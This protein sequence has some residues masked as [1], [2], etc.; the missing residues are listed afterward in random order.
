MTLYETLYRDIENKGFNL[1]SLDFIFQM[2]PNNIFDLAQLD[3]SSVS[4]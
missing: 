4:L 1:D 3:F 2:K